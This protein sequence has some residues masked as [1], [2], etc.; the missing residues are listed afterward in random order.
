M[1]V[2]LF[3]ERF[4][5]LIVS[6][7]KTTTIRATAW[8]KPG[9]DLSLRKW[10][11]KPY[12]SKQAVLMD[13]KCQSVSPIFVDE[14]PSPQD[15]LTPEIARGDGFSSVEEMREFFRSVHGLPFHGDLIAWR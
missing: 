9:D 1:R 10:T 6:G 5:D 7:Q 11:G 2:F 13:T 4:A 12:R 8:C 15:Q 14:A 3:K